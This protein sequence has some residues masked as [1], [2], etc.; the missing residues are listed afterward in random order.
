MFIH[1]SNHNLIVLIIIHVLLA[2]PPA[3]TL[4]VGTY[5]GRIAVY[6]IKTMNLSQGK[7]ST[8]LLPTGLYIL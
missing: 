1:K 4:W 5:S 8:E 7:S 6:G 3:M 2:Q